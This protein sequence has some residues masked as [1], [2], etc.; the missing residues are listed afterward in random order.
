MKLLVLSNKNKTAL[1]KIQKQACQSL[2]QAHDDKLINVTLGELL[3][4]MWM[5]LP[6]KKVGEWDRN[7]SPTALPPAVVVYH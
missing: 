5:K 3:Y 7:V 6:Q 2:R 4:D 1:D